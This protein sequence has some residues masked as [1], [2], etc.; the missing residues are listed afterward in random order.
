MAVRTT[1]A[2]VRAIIDTLPDLSDSGFAPFIKAANSVVNAHCLASLYTEDL[3]T[4]IETWLAA[5]YYAIFDKQTA[6]EQVK[7]AMDTY[8]SKIGFF[9]RL[10]HYGQMAMTLDYDGNLAA[11]SNALEEAQKVLPGSRRTVGLTWLGTPKEEVDEL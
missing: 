1:A 10:T 4:D 11:F 7:D 9:L 5:H 3:L 2:K 8:Q 6:N